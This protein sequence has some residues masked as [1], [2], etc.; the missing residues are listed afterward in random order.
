M[1]AFARFIIKDPQTNE[2]AM[3]S[4]LKDPDAFHKKSL[5]WRDTDPIFQVGDAVVCY[6]QF[7][8]HPDY[9]LITAVEE[10]TIDYNRTN[11]VGYAGKPSNT[12]MD[13]Y[14]GKAIFAFHLKAQ[15][16]IYDF[17]VIADR[18]KVY[19][20]LDKEYDGSFDPMVPLKA[21]PKN[22]PEFGNDE[23]TKY[24]WYSSDINPNR[25]VPGLCEF[26]E[27][28]YNSVIEFT[29]EFVSQGIDP[30]FLYKRDDEFRDQ[31]IEGYSPIHVEISKDRPLR[32][33]DA[34]DEYCRK[35]IN[36]LVAKQRKT[37]TKED[38]Q[39]ILDGFDSRVEGTYHNHAI[40]CDG[41]PHEPIIDIYYR[42][43]EAPTKEHY[44]SKAVMILAHEY[45]HY[46]HNL[47]IQ[48]KEFNLNTEK[49]KAVKEALA[50]CFA[51]AYMEES[52]KKLNKDHPYRWDELGKAT[53]QSWKEKKGSGWPY[54]YAYEIW[55][56][57]KKDRIDKFR[58]IVNA[59][60]IDEAF[61]IL[62]NE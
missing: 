22:P 16:L 61:D 5:Y 35:K 60:T 29:K 18:I 54:A 23:N 42:N 12:K 55:K 19:D 44:F 10:V 32:H 56:K 26:L 62:V 1:G 52:S 21:L 2:H 37:Y 30:V 53:I 57:P 43:F 40:N 4:Y 36:Q 33:Q 49:A 17:E 3:K 7:P 31:I 28:E 20:L 48:N 11:D 9:W 47:H 8:D 58:K 25:K 38:I 51:V 39:T 6:V 41:L 45:M 15:Q 14:L 24:V 34:S 46:V 27:E 13:S 59:K 50:D